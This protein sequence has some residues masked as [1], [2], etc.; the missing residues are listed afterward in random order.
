MRVW[1]VDLICCLRVDA[2]DVTAAQADW[3][4]YLLINAC[5]D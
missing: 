3:S 1:L 2:V 5:T 4:N